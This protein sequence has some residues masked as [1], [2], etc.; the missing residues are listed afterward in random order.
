MPQPSLLVDDR[1]QLY[2]GAVQV[3]DADLDFA[4]RVF[5]ARSGRPL[6]FLREDFCGTALL[7]CTWVRRGGGRRAIGVDLAAEP[8]RWA[9]AHNLPALGARGA[10]VRLV[11]QD[12]RAVHDPKVEAVLALNFSYWI[13]KT[14]P[15]LVEYLRAARR[16][17]LPGGVLVLDAFGGSEAMAVQSDV[18]RIPAQTA[19]DGTALPRYVYRW[20][21]ER[22]DPVRHDFTCSID[23][24]LKDGRVLKRAFRYDWRFWT[25]PELR[26][27]LA[28][29]GFAQSAVYVDDWD[30]KGRE[31][32]GVYRRRR[33]FE[34]EGVWVGYVVGLT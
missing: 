20:N 31:S 9:R 23:F 17:L 1:H 22:F 7:A 6:R 10:S 12:V 15:A 32:D 30:E 8:L 2:Q 21:Q 11:Q 16:S 29:A 34:H 25:L 33:T 4:A 26:E 24:V 27:M 13:F 14:R 3:A 28:E 18:R 5:R 19:F